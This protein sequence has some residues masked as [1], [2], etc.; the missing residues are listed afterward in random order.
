MEL[1]WQ[2]KK[3]QIKLGFRSDH[4]DQR[5]LN[6]FEKLHFTFKKCKLD[7][8][9]RFPSKRVIALIYLGLFINCLE[10]PP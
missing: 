6:G 10:G 7:K 9:P 3:Q 8:N 2:R 4:L 1:N 5:P